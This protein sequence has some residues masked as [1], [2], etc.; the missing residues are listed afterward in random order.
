MPI[1]HTRPRITS[2]FH[3]CR[4]WHERWIRLF[5]VQKIT[6]L[7]R[8]K[9]SISV[10]FDIDC[11]WTIEVSS[12]LWV[13]KGSNQSC[14]GW[15]AW[16]THQIYACGFSCQLKWGHSYTWLKVGSWRW[17]LVKTQV[18]HLVEW[19]KYKARFLLVVAV[20]V[21]CTKIWHSADTMS[22]YSSGLSIKILGLYNKNL[23]A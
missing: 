5:M 7:E 10:E 11:L 8:F 1:Q 18:L 14:V 3:F 12:T 4:V 19:D 22:F 16:V 23:D 20:S 17:S 15:S 9:P 6:M 21:G 13:M 2:S